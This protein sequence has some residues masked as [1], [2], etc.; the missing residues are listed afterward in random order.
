MNES[1]KARAAMQR[2]TEDLEAIVTGPGGYLAGDANGDWIV[3]VGDVV[4]LVNYLYKSGSPPDPLEAGDTN[5]DQ[6]VNVGEVVFLVN[7]LY[8]GGDPPPC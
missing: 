6:V 8:R 7:Y 1:H 3:D 4:Y 2:I 5:C